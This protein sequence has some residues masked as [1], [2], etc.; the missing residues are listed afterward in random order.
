MDSCE[1]V[2][3]LHRARAPYWKYVCM[4]ALGLPG[5]CSVRSTKF[6]S[7]ELSAVLLFLL[8]ALVPFESDKICSRTNADAIVKDKNCSVTDLFCSRW[9]GVRKSK[10]WLK[11][12]S[13][14]QYFNFAVV[15]RMKEKIDTLGWD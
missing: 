8:L 3:V 10:S 14:L 12:Q 13:R 1:I 11:V 2:F 15:R 5:G 7:L 4:R 6:M 9:F